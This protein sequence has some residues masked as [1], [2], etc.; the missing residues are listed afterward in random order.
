M[1]HYPPQVIESDDPL[2][3]NEVAMK[4]LESFESL[5]RLISSRPDFAR[6]LAPFEA[7]PKFNEAKGRIEALQK[8]M[9]GKNDAVEAEN[10]SALGSTEVHFLDITPLTGVVLTSSVQIIQ[11]WD[12]CERNAQTGRGYYW[13]FIREPYMSTYFGM[14]VFGTSGTYL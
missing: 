3:R 13:L 11:S 6:H 10:H 2:R 12:E 4:L 14:V 5:R 7:I 8:I 1:T 9:K